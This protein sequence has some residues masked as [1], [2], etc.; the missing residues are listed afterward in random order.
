MGYS[1][2]GHNESDTTEVTWQAC[3]QRLVTF[4]NPGQVATVGGV[5]CVLAVH[6]TL[7]TQAVCSRDSIR[8][9]RGSFCCCRL[10]MWV[11]WWAWLAP[12][13]LVVRLCL[14]RMFLTAG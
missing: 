4:L 13:Q 5:L 10:T 11:I 9:L 14:M 12:A 6:S 1:P 8:G 2:Q 3:T 7:I